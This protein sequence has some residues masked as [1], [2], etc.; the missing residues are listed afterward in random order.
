MKK[1]I[2]LGT[3]LWLVEGSV[4]WAL[5]DLDIGVIIQTTEEAGVFLSE[6]LKA[7]GTPGEKREFIKKEIPVLYE[8]LKTETSLSRLFGTPAKLI[9]NYPN[10]MLWIEVTDIC[11]QNC[12]QCYTKSTTRGHFLDERILRRVVYQASELKFQQIQFTG[13]EPFLYPDLWDF[14]GYTRELQNIPVI[15]IYT[16]LTLLEN[17]DIELMK[18]YKVKV[19]TTLLGSCTEVHDRCTRTKGSFERLIKNIRKVRDAGIEFRVGVVRLPENQDDI[20]VLEELMHKEKFISSKKSCS[21]DDVRPIGRGNDYPVSISE[22]SS[23]LYLH[24]NREYF[25]MAHYWNT[26]WGGELAITSQGKILPCIFAR[27]RILGN[28]Y[29]QSLGEIVNGL[30]QNYWRISSDKIDKCK[31]CEYRYACMDCRVLS[32]KSGRGLFSK[33]VRCNYDPYR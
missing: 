3:N 8:A 17:K 30:A 22:Q 19:A 16:N 26:C 20:P 23:D 11:N 6:L 24:I 9:F 15:E 10:Y 13:G 32:L 28:I 14:I 25:A 4:R 1:N 29:K 33:P 27:D 31:D 21:P 12:L 5:Y 2:A 7:K 18:R